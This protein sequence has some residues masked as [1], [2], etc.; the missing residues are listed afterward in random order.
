MTYDELKEI[1]NLP[2]DEKIKLSKRYIK[3]FYELGSGNVYVSFSGGKDST[4]MLDIVRKMYPETDAIFVDTGL[5]YPEL[6]EHVKTYDN[7]TWLRPTVPFREVI[8]N[9]GYPVVS[10]KVSRYVRDLKNPTPNNYNTRHMRLTGIMK[11]GKTTRVGK[12]PEKWHYLVDAPFK[13]SERCCDKL[14]KEPMAKYERSAKKWGSIVGIMADES[15]YR[16]MEAL[17][18]GA[19]YITEKKKKCYPMIFWTNQDILEYIKRYNL[20]IPSVYGR[21]L[22]DENGKLKCELESRTGCIFCMFGVHLEKEPNRFQRLEKSHPQLHKYC[23]EKLGCGKVM[24]YINVPY[25]NKK[26]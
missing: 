23:I 26:E 13:I 18:T 2:L 5:E 3:E 10:K 12:L 7:V 24:D 19:M 6:K 11:N 17:K 20:S 25:T 9:Y 16:L 15:E 21:I 22:E 14:K 1:M 8:S 4:V